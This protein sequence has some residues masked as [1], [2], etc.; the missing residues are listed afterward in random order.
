MS[1]A[2][3]PNLNVVLHALRGDSSTNIIST[4]NLLTLDNEAAEIVVGQEVPFVTGN[5]TSTA[6]AT[7][8]TADGEGN[9]VGVV[10]PFQ[11]IERKNVGLTLRITPQ[12]NEGNTIRLE[13]EQELSNVAPIQLQSASD[14]ITNTRTINATVQVEDEQIIVLGGLI[15]DDSVDTHE[16]VPR[17]WKDSFTG[18]IVS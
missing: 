5:F 13:I 3:V 2:V 8:I 18:C 14:L 10:N 6:S 9:A 15:R 7:N 16:W 11:T 12:I 17:A 4:P 1:G